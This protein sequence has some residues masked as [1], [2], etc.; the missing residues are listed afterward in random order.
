MNMLRALARMGPVAGALDSL[1]DERLGIIAELREVPIEAGAPSFFHYAATGSDTSAFVAQRNFNRT[2]G[3]APSREVAVA[4]AVGEAV[5]RYSAAIYT[6]DALPAASANSA[7]FACADPES[8]ALYSPDQY[9][10]PGFP[11]IPF[12]RDTV[13]RWTPAARVATGEP[14]HVPAPLVWIPYTFVRGAGDGPIVQP[15]S[16]GLACHGSRARAILSG[17]Y[18][19]VERDCF[20]LAWQAGTAPPRLRI[21][22]APDSV[23][24]LVS[25]FEETGSKVALLDIST[26]NGISCILS[27]LISESADRPARVFAASADLDPER[28]ACKALEELAHTRRYSQQLLRHLPRVSSDNDWEDVVTQMDHLRFAAD[29]ENVEAMD[30]LLASPERRSFADYRSASSGPEADLD[31]AVQRVERT[32]HPVLAAELTPPDIASFGLHVWRVV[33]PGYHPLFMG[34]RIRALGGTRLYEVPQRLGHAGLSP[35]TD[36]G[37]PHPYP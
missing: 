8:F 14:V 6:R 11:W 5:E 27:V 36:R 24:D 21:E 15:I 3:A 13:V 37:L 10:E 31:E 1:C 28:A 32:G 33:V 12:T 7:T 18:E 17:L 9:R 22:T 34:H 26:D 20:T 35:F 2:G 29:P 19:V 16:T 4:K 30:V 25:R 23:Y